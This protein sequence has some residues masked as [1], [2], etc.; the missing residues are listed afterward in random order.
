MTRAIT[1]PAAEAGLVRVFALSL[2]AAEAQHLKD[3]P[4]AESGPTPQEDA[5]GATALNST[6]VEVF[7]LADLGDMSLPDYLAEGPGV[8]RD[9]LEADRAK[10]SALEGWVMIVYSSAFG[11]AAQQLTP[12]PALTLIGTYP[13]EGVDW[14][15]QVDLSTTSALPYQEDAA[16][17]RKK[18]SD[19]AMSGRIATAAL[20]VLFALVGLMVWVGS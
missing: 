18:P 9:A 12:A 19:A 1:V 8:A 15:D 17:A 4:R 7:A 2:Q 13:Q 6:H 14:S 5:L 11:G 16:P 3:N 10:L 20:L